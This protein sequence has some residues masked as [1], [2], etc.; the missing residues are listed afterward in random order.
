MHQG[1]VGQ[2]ADGFGQSLGSHCT[3]RSEG[4]PLAAPGNYPRLTGIKSEDASQKD[5]L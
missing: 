3:Q 4:A 5:D 1:P 2:S